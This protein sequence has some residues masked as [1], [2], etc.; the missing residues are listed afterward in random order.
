MCTFLD[1]CPLN[2]FLTIVKHWEIHVA[3]QVPS[4]TI[5]KPR[6]QEVHGA[7]ILTTT[8]YSTM[9]MCHIFFISSSVLRHLGCF[10][11]L[12]IMDR[13]AMNVVEQVPL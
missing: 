2:L 9:Q 11:L 3:A 13:A 8:K 4:D 7:I 6:T 12:A 1:F 10:Q 5:L